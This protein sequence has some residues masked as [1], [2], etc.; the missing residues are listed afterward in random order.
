MMHE[1]KIKLLRSVVWLYP[2]CVLSTMAWAQSPQ[3]NSP[4]RSA[5]ADSLVV[6]THRPNQEPATKQ[7]PDDKPST[8]YWM[9]TACDE[10][11]SLLR[12][13][14]NI[15]HGLAVHAVAKDSPAEKSGI[16]VYDIV[17]SVND[18]PLRTLIDLGRAVQESRG[19]EISVEILRGGKKFKLDLRPEVKPTTLAMQAAVISLVGDELSPQEV[20]ELL[21]KAAPDGNLHNKQLLLFRPGVKLEDGTEK[22]S[23]A[24]SKSTG[25]GGAQMK[26]SLDEAIILDNAML[27]GDV[28]ISG[29]CLKLI[30]ALDDEME[31]SKAKIADCRQK[32]AATDYFTEEVKTRDDAEL[33]EKRYRWQETVQVNEV[34]LELLREIQARLKAKMERQEK[35]Q[36][37]DATPGQSSWE[38]S[39]PEIWT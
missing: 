2:L 14:L 34:R 35:S 23:V 16:Q 32:L 13:H 3:N 4:S 9:G 8:L 20:A 39:L 10:P 33:A 26:L 29:C 27:D 30:Q 11:S 5:V 22:G 19:D 12:S 31:R 7:E 15:E 28:P 37:E 38:K 6:T 25:S 18:Q 36:D 1:P 17:L 24:G 21:K